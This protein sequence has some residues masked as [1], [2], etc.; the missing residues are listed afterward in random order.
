MKKSI[1]AVIGEIFLIIV[2]IGL[3]LE[4]LSLPLPHIV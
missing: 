1:D 3:P 2:N 4:P